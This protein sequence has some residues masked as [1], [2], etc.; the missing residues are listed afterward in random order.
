MR[1]QFN[2]KQ[3][4]K[5]L[6]NLTVC[7]DTRENANQHIIDFFNGKKIP[8]KTQKLPFGDY[9]IMLP[10]NSFE[11]QKQDIY[12]YDDFVIERKANLDELA[13][14]LKDDA[15]RLKK[16]LAHLNM[17]KIKFYIFLEDEKYHE[18]IRNG[19]YRSEYDPF[20]FMQRLK[21]GIEAEYSTMIIPVSK[22]CMG[23]E[24]YYTLQAF[25]YALFKHKGFILD[26]SESDIN[27]S[28]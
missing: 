23:S 24:I 2:D 19:E 26:E 13:G 4:K 17:N 10:E 25:V 6:D 11:G 7:V 15:S 21:K 14:N 1:Y 9:S 16:E 28:L 3:L 8:Y 22:K 18:H 27:G 5:I 20:T 12:F